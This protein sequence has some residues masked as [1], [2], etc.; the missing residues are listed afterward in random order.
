MPQPQH[1]F[2]QFITDIITEAGFTDV[3]SEFQTSFHERMQLAFA[4]RLG[5]EA[6]ALLAEPELMAFEKLLEENAQPDPNH[7]YN[8]FTKSIPDFDSR[9]LGI[10]KQF[11][12]EFLQTASTVTSKA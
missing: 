12:T 10:M 1:V 11:R 6:V 8:F 7:I 2:H 9:L 3:S 4:K 5:I